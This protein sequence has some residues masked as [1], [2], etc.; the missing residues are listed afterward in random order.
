LY[1]KSLRDLEEISEIIHP[2]SDSLR[3][4]KVQI[5]G[6]TGYVG[7]WLT[8]A[9]I[10]HS[11]RFGLNTRIS[12]L[13]RTSVKELDS[14]VIF[15]EFDFNN[16]SLEFELADLVFFAA[17]P[18]QPR[19]GGQLTSAV[20]N[21]IDIGLRSLVRRYSESNKVVRFVNCSSGA[22]QAIENNLQLDSRE[23]LKMVKLAEDPK[24]V[25]RDSKLLS[26]KLVLNANMSDNFTGTNARLW[27][28]YGLGISIDSHFAIGNFMRNAISRESVK[29]NGNPETRRSYMYPTNMVGA[30]IQA[31]FTSESPSLNIGSYESVTIGDLA[32]LITDVFQLNSVE[33]LNPSSSPTTYFPV[34]SRTDLKF[35]FENVKLV[36]GLQRWHSDLIA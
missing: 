20:L 19:T 31:A 21:S 4:T 2:F 36:D 15:H 13:G 12:C 26:E 27:T 10:F 30:L 8:E 35:E 9:L 16:P 29:V 22:V 1:T 23:I 25:Y 17:T 7:R 14:Y 11:N 33:Y 24:T 6:A 28:F 34:E 5:I 18:S 32:H 3:N